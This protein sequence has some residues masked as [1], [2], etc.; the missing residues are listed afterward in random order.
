WSLVGMGVVVGAIR[1]LSV[2]RIAIGYSL[3][4]LH[5]QL[6][7]CDSIVP[8]RLSNRF[9]K[10]DHATVLAPELFDVGLHS[11]CDIL[12]VCRESFSLLALVL[13]LCELFHIVPAPRKIV[14][15][16]AEAEQS[17]RI[18]RVHRI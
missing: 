11:V 1:I 4:G 3:A 7:K 12:A 13:V 6:P 18:D 17:E 2:G 10:R 5:D 16:I 14:L 15:Q 9:K 8:G